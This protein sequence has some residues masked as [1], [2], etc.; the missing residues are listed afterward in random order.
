M[1]P[2]EHRQLIEYWIKRL[3]REKEAYIQNLTPTPYDLLTYK[4]KLEQA[5]E[6]IQRLKEEELDYKIA[7]KPSSK[8]IPQPGYNGN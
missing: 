7:F 4:Q 3:Q 8:T 2:E 6:R 1:S 5:L